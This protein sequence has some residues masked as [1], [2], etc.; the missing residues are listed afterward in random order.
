MPERRDPV[1]AG[2]PGSFPPLQMAS[3]LLALS[4]VSRSQKKKPWLNQHNNSPLCTA[5][6]AIYGHWI[7]IKRPLNERMPDNIHAAARLVLA[8]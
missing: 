5:S 2:T 1:R 7:R 8:L 6:A 4:G 3:P